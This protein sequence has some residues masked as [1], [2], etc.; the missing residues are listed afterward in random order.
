[1]F[2]SAKGVKMKALL[3]CVRVIANRR[4][5]NKQAGKKNS[6]A[7]PDTKA[8]SS[9]SGEQT[10]NCKI[11]EMTHSVNRAGLFCFCLCIRS[12]VTDIPPSRCQTTHKVSEDEASQ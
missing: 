4:R 6:S 2:S 7:T 9:G 1:M 12:K 11:L 8:G 5:T 3:Q 10:G